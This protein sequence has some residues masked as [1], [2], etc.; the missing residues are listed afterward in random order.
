M[1]LMLNNTKA[2]VTYSLEEVLNEG[3]K[4][5]AI[6][7]LVPFS[8]ENSC[9]GYHPSYHLKNKEGKIITN[10]DEITVTFGLEP[11]AKP[12]PKKEYQTG[13]WRDPELE[14]SI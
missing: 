14:K 9:T 11:D 5:M 2:R 12:E 7:G 3:Y 1:N 4:I 8:Q 10:A 6:K 13:D